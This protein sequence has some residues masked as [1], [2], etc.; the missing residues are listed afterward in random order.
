MLGPRPPTAQTTGTSTYTS[1]RLR[2]TC[3]CAGR[4]VCCFLDRAWRGAAAKRAGGASTSTNMV[5]AGAPLQG[6]AQLPGP[7]TQRPCKPQPPGQSTPTAPVA[8]LPRLVSP[9]LASPRLPSPPPRFPLASA[10]S[11][12]ALPLRRVAAAGCSGAPAS[13]RTPPTPRPRR[14]ASSRRPTAASASQ[15]ASES[16]RVRPV[17]SPSTPP[18]RPPHIRP[19]L[20]II[21]S[22]P[23]CGPPCPGV[24]RWTCDG[25]RPR[26]PASRSTRGP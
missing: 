19:E 21:L 23:A 7:Q 2:G 11:R 3:A 25:P 9:R 18:S 16:A 12:L 20:P 8:L 14:P 24:N 17:R 1:S 4:V 5:S 26:R 22:G 13:V 6:W 10:S 15:S